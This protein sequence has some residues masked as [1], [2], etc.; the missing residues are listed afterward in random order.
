MVN[1]VKNSLAPLSGSPS[2]AEKKV[3]ESPRSPPP[4]P[5]SPLVEKEDKVEEEDYPSSQVFSDEEDFYVRAKK[6]KANVI[7]DEE[8]EEERRI[9][10][11][12]KIQSL[13]N[14]CTTALMPSRATSGSIGYDVFAMSE[15][16]VRPRNPT[17]VPLGFALIPPQN[18]YGQLFTKSSSAMEGLVVLGGVIDPDYRGEVAAILHNMTDKVITLPKATAVCQLIFI[19]AATPEI[20]AFHVTG[21]VTDRGDRGCLKKK[22]GG[23]GGCSRK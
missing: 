21:D 9:R 17:V 8:D 7:R 12:A 2:T 23:G 11:S 20:R 15:V 14:G 13:H 22:E 6:I 5:H 3:S 16:T 19:Q 10:S 4:P 1:D 18:Y